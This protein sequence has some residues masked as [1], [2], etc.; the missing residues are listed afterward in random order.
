MKGLIYTNRNI[1]KEQ[2]KKLD[3]KNTGYLSLT[4]WSLALTK[5]MC[6]ERIPWL[7]YK[8]MLVEYNQKKQMVKYETSFDNCDGL[9]NLNLAFLI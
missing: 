3:P 5:S 8:E 7:K 4:D 1:I 9:L 2:F 6:M